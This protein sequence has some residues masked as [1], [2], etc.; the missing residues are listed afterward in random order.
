MASAP[1][2]PYAPPHSGLLLPLEYF[3]ENASVY[4]GVNRSS[5]PAAA[6]PSTPASCDDLTGRFDLHD[7]DDEAGSSQY[8][9]SSAFA[10][11]EKTCELTFRSKKTDDGEF[12]GDVLICYWHEDDGC[13]EKDVIPCRPSPP[14]APPD[15]P[16]PAVPP[17]P[18]FI[19]PLAPPPPPPTSP[20]PPL[21]PWPQC[22]CCGLALCLCCNTWEQLKEPRVP[23]WYS[24][25]NATSLTMPPNPQSPPPGAPPR[26]R[27]QYR[28]ATSLLSMGRRGVTLRSAQ[29][30]DRRVAAM[31]TLATATGG[32]YITPTSPDAPAPPAD[33]ARALLAEAEAHTAAIKAEWRVAE[34]RR[35]AREAFS[36]EHTAAQQASHA[37]TPPTLAAS[38]VKAEAGATAKAQAA[39]AK[40]ALKA[41]F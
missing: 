5:P 16:H 32:G 4:E 39:K 13:L 19:P 26:V 9:Y 8:C 41:A 22:T 34:A 33:V 23:G 21:P 17:S 6:P 10:S 18:P 11:L 28:P 12:I 15:A 35:T 31:R 30:R 29:A 2:P 3:Y 1:S 24:E 36:Q 20:P 37:L 38:A 27:Q 25:A 7:L 14:P 40:A